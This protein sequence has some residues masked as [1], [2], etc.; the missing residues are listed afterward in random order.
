MKELKVKQ[1]FLSLEKGDLLCSQLENGDF[2]W[3]GIFL[4]REKDVLYYFILNTGNKKHFRFVSSGISTFIGEVSAGIK[5]FKA[6]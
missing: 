1:D 2:Y 3:S 4:K 6:N 5:H